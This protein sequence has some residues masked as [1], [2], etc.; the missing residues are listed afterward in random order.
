MIQTNQT[1]SHQYT[2]K[3]HLIQ[4]TNNLLAFGSFLISVSKYIDVEIG[5]FQLG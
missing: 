2:I 4:T 3:V 1:M 5:G